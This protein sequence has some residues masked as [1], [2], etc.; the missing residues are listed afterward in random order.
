MNYKGYE[1]SQTIN[2]K[3]LFFI[4]RSKAGVVAFRELSEKKLKQAIDDHFIALEKAKELAEAKR[5]RLLANEKRKQK[6]GLFQAK[7]PKPGVKKAQAKSTSPR[8]KSFWG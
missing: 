7:K 5:K 6:R 2:G 4:A 1:L 3:V 8:K